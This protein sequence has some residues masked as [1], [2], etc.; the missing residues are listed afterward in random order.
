[1]AAVELTEDAYRIACEEARQAGRSPGD[2][3]ASLIYAASRGP[4]P[5]DDG[6]FPTALP[7]DYGLAAA[8]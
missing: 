8:V 2:W 1:V 6:G 4:L 5:V 3:I 7:E